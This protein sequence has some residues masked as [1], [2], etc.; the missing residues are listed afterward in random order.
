MKGIITPSGAKNENAVL[1]HVNPKSYLPKAAYRDRWV[2]R[3]GDGY[4]LRWI[5]YTLLYR[6]LHYK[7]G[8]F[9]QR[10]AVL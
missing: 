8:V 7:S 2:C 5:R 6:D 9:M 4:D 1:Q 10:S 3:K